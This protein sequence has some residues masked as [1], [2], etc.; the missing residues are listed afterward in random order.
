MIVNYLLNNDEK[1][2]FKAFFLK[3]GSEGKTYRAWLDK[4]LSTYDLKIEKDQ[5]KYSENYTFNIMWDKDNDFLQ[6]FLKQNKPI[7]SNR[8]RYILKFNSSLDKTDSDGNNLLHLCAKEKSHH[9]I[10]NWLC[11]YQHG[12]KNQLTK[13]GNTYHTLFMDNAV[14]LNPHDAKNKDIFSIVFEI[15]LLGHILGQFNEY[16]ITDNLKYEKFINNCDT[17][18]KNL[19][20]FVDIM[21]LPKSGYLPNSFLGETQNFEKNLN[22]IKLSHDLKETKPHKLLKI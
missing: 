7:D 6:H 21:N 20:G 13:D 16:L 19:Y 5:I 3:E 2:I 22:Y 11:T 17:I 18:L 12:D 14:L 15:N 1:K 10:L 8:F 9:W 4:F